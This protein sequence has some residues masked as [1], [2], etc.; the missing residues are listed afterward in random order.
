M[1]D[2][3]SVL[4]DFFIRRF[5]FPRRHASIYRILSAR[6]YAS[7][8]FWQLLRYVAG[9]MLSAIIYSITYL[10]LVSALFPGKLAVI[11][12]LP[13]FVIA[14]G[15][16]LYIH[17]NWTFRGHNQQ[18]NGQA[19]MF[20]FLFVQIAGLSMTSVMT[21]GVTGVF[22][23]PAWAAIIP[24]VLVTPLFTFSLQRMWV[25]ADQRAG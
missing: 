7:P 23:G 15:C 20:R 5:D 13:A 3:R 25:F 10:W 8:I 4:R 22:G 18:S 14:A 17:S 19:L 24:S 1:A 21:W 12:V 11:A 6:Y 9:G 2:Q 16:G